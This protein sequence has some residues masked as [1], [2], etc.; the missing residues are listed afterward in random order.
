MALF[1]GQSAER[2]SVSTAHKQQVWTD[3]V[4]TLACCEHCRFLNAVNLDQVILAQLAY[5]FP[6]KYRRFQKSFLS[7]Y[8]LWLEC[9]KEQLSGNLS[10]SALNVLSPRISMN[11][12]LFAV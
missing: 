5:K 11:L 8:F 9:K 6:W 1:L 12:N 3:C 7:F 10:F 4:K 2:D